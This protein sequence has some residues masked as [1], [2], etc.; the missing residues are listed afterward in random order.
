MK[1]SAHAN[2]NLVEAIVAA[3]HDSAEESYTVS[4]T[5][6][7]GDWERTYHWID[8]S[9]MA[10]YFLDLVERLHIQTA[11]PVATLARLRQIAKP[12]AHAVRFY[13]RN[14]LLS[15]KPFSKRVFTT[16]TS[17]AFR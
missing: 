14:S 6:K 5:F 12:T 3:F 10:L 9:G 13:L 1:W 2:R 7:S 15:M 17:R 16:R 11:L 8:A 4:S